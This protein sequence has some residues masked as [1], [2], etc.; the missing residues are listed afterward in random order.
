MA[1]KPSIPISSAPT[2]T[3]SASNGSSL[4]RR[5]K[6]VNVSTS[7]ANTARRSTKLSSI[8]KSSNGTTTRN[9]DSGS[10]YSVKNKNSNENAGKNQSNHVAKIGNAS[11][12]QGN[13]APQTD[14]LMTT[15]ASPTTMGSMGS[16]YMGMGMGYSGMGMGY[17]GMG[18][19]M[20]Y[21]GMGMGYGMG[22]GAGGSAIMTLNQ[23]LFGFQSLIFSLGQAIQVVGMN[24]QALHNL[25]EQV[26]A[27]LDQGLKLVQE[28]RTLEN[29]EIQALSEED[30]KRRRRLKALRWSLMFGIS[31]AGYSFVSKWFKKRKE[32]KRRK[33]LVHTQ[34]GTSQYGQRFNTQG[35]MLS[36]Q[37]PEG[38]VG[39]HSYRYG[40]NNSMNDGYGYG[41]GYG[42][43]NYYPSSSGY[44]YSGEYYNNNS[45]YYPY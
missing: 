26:M 3:T 20:G 18:M 29:Q 37:R 14:A 24:T 42:Q 6:K 22:M 31:Y 27:M 7:N 34:G 4:G 44:G 9:V 43:P 36:S 45:S 19:G 2:A 25:Y 41:N 40:G 10:T 12:A 8:A 11:D 32:Y 30:Q 23:Y 28:L 38:N 5:L 16:P 1:P 17:G 33:R 21:G 35:R 13:E 39:Q 15:G